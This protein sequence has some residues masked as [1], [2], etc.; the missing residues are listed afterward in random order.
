MTANITKVHSC[1]GNT[2]SSNL[3]NMIP[4]VPKELFCTFPQDYSFFQLSETLPTPG[5]HF[6]YTL[7]NWCVFSIW[8]GMNHVCVCV[9]EQ[10]MHLLWVTE[11][12]ICFSALCEN[13]LPA[14]RTCLTS[15][16][17]ELFVVH[18]FLLHL[19]SVFFSFIHPQPIATWALFFS[20]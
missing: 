20:A 9:W 5:I 14:G 7:C 17:S 1:V 3:H 12:P 4:I 13:L 10:Q 8:F 6:V 2:L 15:C 18:K 19:A 11:G 16:W